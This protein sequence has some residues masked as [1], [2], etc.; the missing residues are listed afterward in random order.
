M[1][2]EYH[3]PTGTVL[4]MGHDVF[5]R[6]GKL[7]REQPPRHTVYVVRSADGSWSPL[8]RLTWD[9]PRGRYIY[10]CNC[11]QRVN[12]PGGDV[13]VPLSIGATSAARSVVVVRCAF[14]GVELAVRETSNELTNKVRRGL[15]EPS[16]A[17][18]GGRFFLTIRAE[19]DH[20]Y[21]STSDDGRTWSPQTPWK[22]DDGTAIGM[23]STQQ[24]WLVDRHALY[25]VYTRRD[26]TN[27]GVVRWRA[28][29]YA[30]RVDP[31]TL[32]LVRSTER[33]IVPLA[34]DGV[35][36]G[37]NVPHLGN[38]HVNRATADES[39]ITVGD[40]TTTQYRGDVT[41]ARV[42]WLA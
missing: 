6:D 17:E 42:H 21:V 35:N 8:R 37:P 30:A 23:S 38:F 40:C 41:L 12:L 10:T 15:L 18:F 20:G 26:P 36:D 31:E 25:L 33:I 14:D 13:L 3:A 34:G 1:V 16:L 39:G 32:R 28:P 19:D 7:I 2:P 29:L 24:R 9:D 4:A 27:V 22:F 11:A 5:Y